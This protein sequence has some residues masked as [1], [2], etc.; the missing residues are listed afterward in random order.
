MESTS[1]VFM[2]ADFL[3]GF[4]QGLLVWLLSMGCS[5]TWKTFRQFITPPNLLEGE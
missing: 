3:A 5:A 1:V 4:S 2:S